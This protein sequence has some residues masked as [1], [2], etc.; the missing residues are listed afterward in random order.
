MARIKINDLP[1]NQKINKEELKKIKGGLTYLRYTLSNPLVSSYNVGGTSQGDTVPSEEVSFNFG[2]IGW[3][4][5]ETD[6]TGSI[7]GNVESDW[8]ISSNENA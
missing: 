2:K 5:T 1:R 7:S 4:Y 8:E 3:T 6:H